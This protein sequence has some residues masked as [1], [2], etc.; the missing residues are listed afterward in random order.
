[1]ERRNTLRRSKVCPHC[2][3]KVVVAPVEVWLVKKLV[4]QIDASMREGQGNEDHLVQGHESYQGLTAQEQEEAKGA[5]LPSSKEIW[6]DIFDKN[7]RDEPLY[8]PGDGVYRC[9]FCMSEV[10]NGACQN[11]NCGMIYNLDAYDSDGEELDDDFSIGSAELYDEMDEDDLAFINDHSLSYQRP[12]SILSTDD[13]YGEGDSQ[14]SLSDGDTSTSR[15]L[16]QAHLR[17]ESLANRNRNRNRI[18]RSRGNVDNNDDDD[19]VQEVDVQGRPV[20]VRRAMVVISDSESSGDDREHLGNGTHI[21]IGE[22]EDEEQGTLS[23]EGGSAHSVGQG[24]SHLDEDEDD[25][26]DLDDNCLETIQSYG[27]D[28]DDSEDDDDAGQSFDDSS[29]EE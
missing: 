18:A 24:S 13:E 16:I 11:A 2:R 28:G 20:R 17:M 23:G 19:A 3:D 27:E 12:I 9:G 4:D 8:D 15:E 7:A 10:V 22:S 1:M 14:I 25:N 21:T 6:K 29:E 5:N 26:D